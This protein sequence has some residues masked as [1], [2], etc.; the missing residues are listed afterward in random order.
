[1]IASHA[2]ATISD[3][4]FAHECERLHSRWNYHL[5]YKEALYYYNVLRQHYRDEWILPAMGQSCSLL[6]A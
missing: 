6:T 5:P 1:V 3:T 4:M 2:E